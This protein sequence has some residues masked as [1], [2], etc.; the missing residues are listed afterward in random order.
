M[1]DMCEKR[2]IPCF[3]NSYRTDIVWNEDPSRRYFTGT[4]VLMYGDNYHL[5]DVGLEYVSYLYE[6]FIVGELAK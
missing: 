2:G 1:S 5:N 6:D 3:N 4:P